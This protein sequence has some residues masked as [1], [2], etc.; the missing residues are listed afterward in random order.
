MTKPPPHPWTSGRALIRKNPQTSLV[1]TP[2][3]QCRGRGF[4]PGQGKSCMSNGM[5]EENGENPSFHFLP[6][7]PQAPFSSVYLRAWRQPRPRLD[8][9][10]CHA[11]HQPGR[12]DTWR[13]MPT[14]SQCLNSSEKNAVRP[15]T[16]KTP[17]VDLKSVAVGS[18][19]LAVP[20]P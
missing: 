9:P 2:H 16:Q 18:K 17:A 8:G 11:L 5:T 7:I 19:F 12:A 1:K 3:S 15:S 4:D 10:G 14:T 13:A 20:L 6:F